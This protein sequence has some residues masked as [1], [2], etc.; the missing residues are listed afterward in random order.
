MSLAQYVKDTS[1]LPGD[2]HYKNEQSLSTM[3]C[4]CTVCLCESENLSV[5]R[6]FFSVSL[7]NSKQYYTNFLPKRFY[8]FPIFSNTTWI[9]CK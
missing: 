8:S 3:H 6:I 1:V 9:S 5:Y 7:I 2:L 4:V